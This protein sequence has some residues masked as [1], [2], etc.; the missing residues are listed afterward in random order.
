MAVLDGAIVTEGPALAETTN[1]RPIYTTTRDRGFVELSSQDLFAEWRVIS[2]HGPVAREEYYR[3]GPAGGRVVVPI[4]GRSITVHYRVRG[5][6]APGN[7]SDPRTGLYTGAAARSVSVCYL[8]QRPGP[9]TLAL[10]IGSAN[11]DT[12]AIAAA[13]F[14]SSIRVPGAARFATFS[15][16]DGAGNAAAISML[17]RQAVSAGAS[18]FDSSR[19]RI[20][21]GSKTI[22]VDPW[23]LIH[24]AN[25]SQT[26]ALNAL[27]IWRERL[28]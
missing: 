6:D 8:S 18:S 14:L 24:I 21:E 5:A 9:C 15:G 23:S 22:P 10:R 3:T 28:D 2:G 16:G 26:A 13:G 20:T 17:V 1:W 4:V 27:I 7:G 11:D 12:A 19:C 25:E